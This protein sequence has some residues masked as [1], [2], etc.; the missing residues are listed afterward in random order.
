[1]VESG[2]KLGFLPGDSNDKLRPYLLPIYDEFKCFI[3]QE[4]FLEFQFDGSIEVAPLAHMRGRSFHN[5]IIVA[6]ELQNATLD[7]LK[8]LITRLGKYSKLIINGD[9]NQS[10]LPKF[11]Q[12][13]LKIFLDKLQHI[14]GIGIVTLT[15]EDIVRNKLISSILE[16]L[17]TP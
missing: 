12:G 14:D 2:E 15:N 5:C 13:G 7:Q 1:V 17:E 3:S 4:E 9:L 10:D 8:M 11:R 6:D 16:A